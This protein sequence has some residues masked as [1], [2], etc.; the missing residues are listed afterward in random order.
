MVLSLGVAVSCLACGAGSPEAVHAEAGSSN[1]VAPDAGESPSSESEALAAFEREAE[2]RA[3]ADR[4]AGVV[5]VAREGRVR[6]LQS[7]GLADRETGTKMSTDTKLR[8][9]SVS[10]MFTGVATLQLVEA[11]KV[12]LDAPI[13]TYLTDYPNREIATRA[14]VRHLLTNTGGTGDFFGPEYVEH[15]LEYQDN[16]D[17]V[18]LCAARPVEFEPGTKQAYSNCGF[19][20]LGAIIERASGQSYYDYVRSH[21]FAPAQMESTDSLPESV[22]VPGR[23]AGYM[24]SQ[25]EWVSNAP[26]L[27]L[28]GTAAGGGYST[29]QDLFRFDEALRAERLLPRVL[30][31]DATRLQAECCDGYGF[32][33]FGE[34]A[35]RWYGHTGGSPGMNA[36][37]KT[38]PE[39]GY[40]VAILSN[41]DPPSADDLGR[42]FEDSVVPL[43]TAHR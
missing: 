3:A 13:G 10:K 11:K 7:F 20:L 28:R 12:G 31:E 40:T 19:I 23:A 21:V 4:F 29:A 9:G 30:L 5:L 37:L 33:V 27:A 35:L 17:Y 1:R 41:L 2:S 36:A 34:G 8:I 18:K 15:R 43:L 25:R 32:S 16:E 42:Y 22:S 14:T 24:S 6:L 26:V 39:L 38:Y